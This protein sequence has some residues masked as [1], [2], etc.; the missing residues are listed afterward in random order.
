MFKDSVIILDAIRHRIAA[1]QRHPELRLKASKLYQKIIICLVARVGA[2]IS[3][4]NL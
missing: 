3:P 1:F 4:E 2:Q